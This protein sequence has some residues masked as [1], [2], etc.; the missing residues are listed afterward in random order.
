[1]SDTEFKRKSPILLGLTA[2]TAI[3]CW[4]VGLN[5]AQII[6]VSVF[7]LKTYATILFWKFRLPF[8]FIAVFG[9]LF[10]GLL[11]IPHLIEFASFD[12]ILFLIGMM[13]I[14]GT[15]EENHFFEYLLDQIMG[16]VKG[17]AKRLVLI[18]M[19]AS[20]FFAAFVDEV[21]SILFMSATVL[22]LT[23]CYGVNPVPFIMMIV[24]A[25]NIG[26]A[27]TVVGNP[28]G[29]MIALK[30][31]F[32]FFD[33]FR[34]ATPISILGLATVVLIVFR[35]FGKE[36]NELNERLKTVD[37]SQSE[38]SYDPKRIRVSMALFL[39]TILTLIFH[40]FIEELFH[41]ER[42]TML[43]GTAL[44][45]GGIALL[46]ERERAQEI[47]ERRVDWWTLTFFI[48][49]FASVGTLKYVG[50]TKFMAEK[51]FV[52]ASASDST[53]FVSFTWMSAVLSAFLDN[54]LAIA[55]FIPI[56]QELKVLGAYDFP[57]WWGMLFAG[58][59]F[60]NLTIIGSTANI[61]AVG[62]LERR[63]KIHITFM[64]WVRVG[65]LVAVPTMV[66]ATIVLLLQFP[67][68]P[69]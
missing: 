29:V 4:L 61:I 54:V 18:L 62:M 45:Y 58:T 39:G 34:W 17:D 31:G 46:W 27:A 25:T 41:L 50:V 6:A 47:I 14:I 20:A 19:V 21:T 16:L 44:L 10:L 30:G 8:A 35:I 37:P 55:T 69:A 36:I 59:F 38:H 26:S 5:T 40:H 65:I 64:Q 7:S 1:M 13:S 57:L 43:I 67:L 28:V 33:F 49:L 51:L 53:L 42:N 9:L 3:L 24:F 52:L 2:A 12:V 68:M 22:H 66:I 48:L 63:K 11:D 32:S 60:G 56:V 15:L 23:G